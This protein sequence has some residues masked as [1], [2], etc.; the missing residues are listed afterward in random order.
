MDDSATERT[1]KEE[2]LRGLC[3]FCLTETD[4]HLDIKGRPYWRCWRFEVRAFGTKTTLRAFTID[5]WIWT[6]DPPTGALRAW[7]TK[8]AESLEAPAHEG[9]RQ[10]GAT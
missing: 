4:V 3:P 8:V 6:G 2:G 5:G 9:P 10:G 7:L 1:G